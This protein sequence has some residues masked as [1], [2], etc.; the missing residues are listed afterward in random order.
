MST[1]AV[2]VGGGAV[3][4]PQI[5]VDDLIA[6]DSGLDRA[7]EAGLSPTLLVGDLDSI[8]DDGLWWAR[9]HGLRVEQHSTDKDDTDTA[10]ALRA[11]VATPHD[12]LLLLGPSSVDRLDHQL[13]T[14]VA[15]GAPELARLEAITAQLGDTVLH[16]LHPGHAVD[17]ELAVG[18]T[19]SLL[20]LHGTCTGIEM[21]GARWPLSDAELQPGRTLG[22]SNESVGGTVHVSVTDG[23]LTVVIPPVTATG[24]AA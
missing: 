10:L 9:E 13:G 8:S 18:T 21:R 20:A 6:A 14:I 17:L 15:L 5:D 1:I 7:L 4:R 2:V 22:I 12:R 16:V 3:P 19:F 23:V 24:V 11:A